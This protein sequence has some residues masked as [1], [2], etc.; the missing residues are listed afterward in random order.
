MMPLCSQIPAITLVRTRDLTCENNVSHFGQNRESKTQVVITWNYPL[1][2]KYPLFLGCW[3]L[4]KL[5]VNRPLRTMTSISEL[6]LEPTDTRKSGPVTWFS[7][8]QVESL[9][10]HWVSCLKTSF[11]RWKRF[12]TSLF[13]PNIWGWAQ[14][15]LR[16]ILFLLERQ[17]F[18]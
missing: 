12:L 3:A 4:S 6:K 8:G 17:M 2:L 5:S 1:N 13:S 15:S 16:V 7:F 18:F 10:F 9:G 11:V 14:H